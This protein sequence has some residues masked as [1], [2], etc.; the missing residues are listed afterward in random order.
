[1]TA[2]LRQERGRVRGRGKQEHVRRG[3][4]AEGQA[5]LNDVAARQERY[6]SQN[7]L[8]VTAVDKVGMLGMTADS[9]TKRY[10]LTLAATNGYT[11]TATPTFTDPKCGNLTLNASGKRNVTSGDKD[12]CWR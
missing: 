3:Y 10:T 1:M 8:Y 12:Y 4:R 7:N 5:F 9:P 6:F 2:G 11:L